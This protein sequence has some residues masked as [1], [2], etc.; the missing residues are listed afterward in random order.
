MPTLKPMLASLVL[1]MMLP[2]CGPQRAVLPPAAVSVQA[3]RPLS[4]RS[5]EGLRKGIVQLRR[6]RFDKWD[7]KP[8]DDHLTRDE[9]SDQNLQLPELN[10]SFADYDANRDGRISFGEFL[11]ED[12]IAMWSA[13]YADITENEFYVLDRN[14]N[15]LIDG[16]ELPALR[17]LFAPW[18]ELQGGDRNGDGRVDFDEFQDSYMQVAPWLGRGR[19]LPQG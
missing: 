6:I 8:K 1:I 10:T 7:L 16:A 17:E 13:L 15:Q 12:V 18:P 19:K 2:A 3:R 14:D 4:A 11:R 5:S 9:V